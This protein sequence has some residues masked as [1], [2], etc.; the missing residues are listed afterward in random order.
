MG[1]KTWES[2]PDRFRPL[3]GRFNIVVTR[4]ADHAVPEGVAV[5]PDLSRAVEI[6]RDRSDRLFVIGGGEIYREAL[7]RVDC[8]DLF[9]T[10]VRGRFDCDVFFPPF[11]DRFERTEVLDEAVEGGISYRIERW[12]RKTV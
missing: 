11:E 7:A 5:A 1:R 3:G 4:R 10:R 2:I 6:G 8:R 9:L 12:I